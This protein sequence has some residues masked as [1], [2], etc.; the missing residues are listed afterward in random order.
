MNQ[1][2]PSPPGE[3]RA[4]RAFAFIGVTLTAILTAY[5][6]IAADELPDRTVTPGAVITRDRTAVCAVGY[7]RSA[8]HRY[9]AEWLRYRTAMF[10]EYGVPHERWRNF[11]VDH[12]VPIELGGEP[13]GIVD[14]RWDLRNVWPEPKAEAQR[15][16]AVEDALHAAVCYRRGYRGVH[17]NLVSAQRAISAD[18]QR[19]PVGMPEPRNWPSTLLNIELGKG[20]VNMTKAEAQK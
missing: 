20:R 3:G 13:F 19:T 16:D 15:K 14:G 7:A 1:L 6:P 11:T 8:R 12:L 18:W 17:L 5:A 10:H 9:D 2:L 4:R